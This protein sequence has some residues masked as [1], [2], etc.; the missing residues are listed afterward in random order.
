M[1]WS[2]MAAFGG[3]MAGYVCGY[4]YYVLRKGRVK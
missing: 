4:A 3:M 1:E 2:T